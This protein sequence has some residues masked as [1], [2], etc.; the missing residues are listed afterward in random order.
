MEL[1][2]LTPE[3]GITAIET[4]RLPL[5][6]ESLEAQRRFIKLQEEGF[7]QPLINKSQRPEAGRPSGTGG[8]SK[9]INEPRNIANSSLKVNPALIKDNLLLLDTLKIEIQSKL[10]SKFKKKNLNAQQKEIVELIAETI[11]S[12]E[13]PS[14]WIPKINEYIE[15]AEGKSKENPA[16]LELSHQLGL[17]YTD[18]ALI[19]HSN[20]NL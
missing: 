6:E 5:P 11:I 12:N 4:G 16:I 20:N 2:V 17:S 9:S 13:T 3:E 14:E 10:K 1:G 19:Y 18:A 15:N 8:I 7:Y